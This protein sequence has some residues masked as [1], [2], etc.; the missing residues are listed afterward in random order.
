MTG[1]ML[2]QYAR[3]SHPP[4]LRAALF[5]ES[6]KRLTWLG[7][8]YTDFPNADVYL[9]G[10]TLRDILI[11]RMPQ[12][13]DLV[14]RNVDPEQLE[15]WLLQ[16]GAAEFVG[17]FGTFKFIPHGCGGSEPIDIALPRTEFIGDK[18]ESA[19]DSMEVK[20]DPSLSIKDDLARRDFTIN[21]M[22]FDT[23]RGRLIDPFLGLN[24]LYANLIQSVL[25]PE[26][27]FYE[28]ATR[29]LRGL[30]FA[31]QLQFGI[32][33]DTWRAMKANI[34]LL[35]NLSMDDD[36]SHR[37][38]VPRESIGREFLLGFVAHPVHT[39]QLW[40]E[41]KALHLYMP[42]LAALETQIESDTKSAYHKT[43]D[44]L[45]LL[46]KKD[47]ARRHG[48]SKASP[49]LLLAGLLSHLEDG[50]DQAYEIC[51]RLYFH[52][53]PSDH[54]AGIDCKR[55]F[56]LLKHVHTFNE[57]DPASM[58]PS[59]FEKLFLN[60]RGAELLTLMHAH[61][62]ASGKHSIARERLHTAARIRGE[63]MR[64][65]LNEGED[66]RLP[67]LITG[68]DIKQ[69]GIEPGPGYRDLLDRVRDAQLTR[70]IVNRDQALNLLDA[71]IAEL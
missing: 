8:F 62:I 61:F 29:I 35:N 55:M 10:G 33:K 53:F 5:V 46:Q 45:G 68:K 58:R 6:E 47:I 34:A 65:M 14:I 44:V 16:H 27:R 71:M 19:R 26:Q 13:I 56:W 70:A 57:T 4:E 7:F 41:A 66:G 39:V 18:H 28:D 3:Q 31:S 49:T 40:K 20:F 52:Q 54:K 43:L 63:L 64:H 23:R 12:D 51:T 42:Q 69:A 25:I 38:V 2:V 59:L 15:Q 24:D 9:V 37:Y 1:G 21:A 32:E 67:R 36:G 60:Q 50:P 22:A 11:G 17:R 48:L 30:R